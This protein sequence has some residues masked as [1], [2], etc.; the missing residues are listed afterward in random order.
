MKNTQS[1]KIEK[2]KS[3]EDFDNFNLLPSD[4][5]LYTLTDALRILEN[6]N[7]G[8]IIE[9]SGKSFLVSYVASKK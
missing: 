1:Y 6:G 8:S 7:G 9:P 2:C 4:G 5:G 3:K